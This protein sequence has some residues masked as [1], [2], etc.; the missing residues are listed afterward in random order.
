MID[1]VSGA[2]VKDFTS[3]A[4]NPL[5]AGRTLCLELL[6][7]FVRHFSRFYFTTALMQDFALHLHSTPEL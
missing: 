2:H 6:R 5:T 7:A 4:Y 3:N 1:L